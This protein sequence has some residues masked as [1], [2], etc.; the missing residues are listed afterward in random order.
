MTSQPDDT[1]R[2]AGRDLAV[3]LTVADL[4]TSLAWYRDVVGFA[5]DR[6]HEH[7]GIVR[8]VSLRA[9]SARLIIN[10]DNGAKGTDRVKGVGFSFMITTSQ[11]ADAL[12]DGITARGGTLLTPPTDMP[13]GARV[14]RLRDPD[15]FVFAVASE[16]E[17]RADV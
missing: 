11:N 12:A 2:F 5:V 3:S 10:Q 9:G 1:D 8:G 4:P 7:D 6:M 17:A 15:G 13:W 14:F 16:A